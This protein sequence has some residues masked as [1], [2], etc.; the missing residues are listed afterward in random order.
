[1]RVTAEQ[2]G[3]HDVAR[4]HRRVGRGDTPVG[5]HPG[6]EGFQAVQG[7]AHGLAQAVLMGCSTR[8]AIGAASRSITTER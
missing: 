3:G 2:V 5:Q 6:D 4:H 8:T 7:Q 1:M